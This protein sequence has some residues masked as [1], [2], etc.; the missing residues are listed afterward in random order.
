[1]GQLKDLGHVVGLDQVAADFQQAMDARDLPDRDVFAG[2][3]EAILVD[4][5]EKRAVIL[6]AGTKLAGDLVLDFDDAQIMALNAGTILC[7]GDL[8]IDGR[9]INENSDEGPFLLVGGNLKANEI[10]KGGARVVVLGDL[11]SDGVIF[12]DDET[13]ALH[14]GGNLACKALI[15]ADHELYTGGDISGVAI[16]DDLGNMRELLVS[17]CFEDPDDPEDQ[18]PLGDL[19]RQRLLDGLAVLK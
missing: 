13:G 9:I 3:S 16:S 15:D 14:V 4:H 11:S 8:T 10:I 2:W 1:M 17:E 5:P 18:W 6:P 7:T 19:I 12:C